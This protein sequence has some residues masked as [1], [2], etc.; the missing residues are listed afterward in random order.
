MSPTNPT[1][2]KAGDDTGPAP[3]TIGPHKSDVLNVLDPKVQ[4]T[5]E[6]LEHMR[7]KGGDETGP[8]PSTIGPHESD[9]ANILDPRVQPDP[10]KLGHEK[11]I[12]SGGK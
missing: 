11:D 5:R 1:S 3:H 7:G 6:N 12:V 8:A 10:K 9:T 4:P 2:N